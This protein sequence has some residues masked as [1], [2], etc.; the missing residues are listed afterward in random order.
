MTRV[1]LIITVLAGFAFAHAIAIFQIDS[2]SP[3]AGSEDA[4]FVASGD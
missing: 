2:M 3:G 1:L 4:P